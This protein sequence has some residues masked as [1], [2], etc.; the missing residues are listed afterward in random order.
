MKDMAWRKVDGA[1]PYLALD[2]RIGMFSSRHSISPGMVSQNPGK[3]AKFAV[4][5][6]DSDG[7]NNT[8]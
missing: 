7:Q 5:F 6:N 1:Y 4:A 8:A 3:G 2:A